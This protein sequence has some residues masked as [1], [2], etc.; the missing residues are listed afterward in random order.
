MRRKP[1]FVVLLAV[2]PGEPKVTLVRSLMGTGNSV[3]RLSNPGFS[4]MLG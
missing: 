1:L 3:N 4:V 2:V